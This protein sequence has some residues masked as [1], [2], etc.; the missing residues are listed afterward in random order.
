MEPRGSEI[1]IEVRGEREAEQ[2]SATRASAA[3][4]KER[5]EERRQ[6]DLSHRS[7]TDRDARF[8]RR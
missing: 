6:D 4:V 8:V 3:P 1:Q 2:R 5:G 7:R